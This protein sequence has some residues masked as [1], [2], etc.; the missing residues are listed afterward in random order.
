MGNKVFAFI[1]RISYSMYLWHWPVEMWTKND[2]IWDFK[3]ENFIYKTFIKIV[4][5]LFLSIL[6]YY[7]VETPFLHHKFIKKTKT[8]TI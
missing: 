7:F 5:T 4:I 2:Q 6:S 3:L 1:G 8:M